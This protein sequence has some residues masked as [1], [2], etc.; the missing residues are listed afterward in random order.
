[1]A[2]A[3]SLLR[4]ALTITQPAK[5]G[6]GNCDIQEGSNKTGQSKLSQGLM[7]RICHSTFSHSSQSMAE[8]VQCIAKQQICFKVEQLCVA[9]FFFNS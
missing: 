4:L 7:D 6:A 8:D 5:I 9:F 1:M 3:R 2:L